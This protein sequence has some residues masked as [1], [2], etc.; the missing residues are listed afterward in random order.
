MRLSLPLLFLLAA[1]SPRSSG[2]EAAGPIENVKAKI[3]PHETLDLTRQTLVH[4]VEFAYPHNRVWAALLAAHEHDGM[5]LTL[6]DERAG[7]LAYEFQ[8]RN[9]D[10]AGKLA[11]SY[12][13]CGMGPAG[14]RATTYRL[15]L[16]LTHQ[17]E[18][19]HKT[20]TRLSSRVHA[21]ARHPGMSSAI[22]ECSSTGAL[23][24]RM[25]GL[26]AAQLTD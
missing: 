2:P 10:L 4:S 8:D 14:P 17:I 22:I 16:R 20:M 15:T 18:S 24:K 25:V 19:S 9:R 13:D 21:S 11:A 3:S 23:E 7:V 6:V 1:C 5:K 12:V 26:V